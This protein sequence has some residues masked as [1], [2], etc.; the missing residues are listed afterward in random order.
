MTGADTDATSTTSCGS[1][2]TSSRRPPTGSGD[3][4]ALSPA[5]DAGR[6]ARPGPRTPPNLYFN[7]GHGHM[8]WTMAFGTARIVTDL[9]AGRKP[10]HDPA[11]LGPRGVA[12]GL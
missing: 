7:A 10:D 5:Y 6:P 3:S 12:G 2:G 9:V 1:R 11:G 4:S 8:G